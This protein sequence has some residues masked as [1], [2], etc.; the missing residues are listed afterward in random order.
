MKNSGR[1]CLHCH[2]LDILMRD[3]LHGNYSKTVSQS[4]IFFQLGGLVEFCDGDRG[5]ALVPSEF[6]FRMMWPSPYPECVQM[7]RENA[8]M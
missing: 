3:G 5:V 6:G 4:N 2:T 8:F 1:V 7:H